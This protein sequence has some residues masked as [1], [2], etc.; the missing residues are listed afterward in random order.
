METDYVYLICLVHLIL[1]IVIIASTTLGDTDLVLGGVMISPWLQ[2]WNATFN[3]ISIISIIAAAIGT[4]YLIESHL[5]IY[6]A[7]LAI[8]IV[9]DVVWFV[10]FLVYG[11]RCSTV[12]SDLTHSSSTVSCGLNFGGIIIG[13]T[14]LILFKVFALTIV[15]KATNT[16]RIRYHEELLPYLR[17]TLHQSLGPQEIAGNKGGQAG[18]SFRSRMPAYTY[19]TAPAPV[20]TAITA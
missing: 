20:S 3:C 15:S 13:L 1:C 19:G 6:Y 12:K 16:I 14:V 18:L 10:V 9:I 17:E 7:I 2:W 4:L 11:T 8:S 5:D